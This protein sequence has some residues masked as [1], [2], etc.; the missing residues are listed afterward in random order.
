MIPQRYDKKNSGS[1]GIGQVTTPHRPQ[2][3]ILQGVGDIKHNALCWPQ[4]QRINFLG[5][6]AVL[7][8]LSVTSSSDMTRFKTSDLPEADVEE[9][10]RSSGRGVDFGAVTLN[11]SNQ[12][13]R[14]LQ[15]IKQPVPPHDKYIHAF[16]TETEKRCRKIT[17]G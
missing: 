17:G 12:I 4:F 1:S 11:Y 6:P 16:V 3:V 5:L 13:T 7:E 2:A 15:G 10:V 8:M 9:R 14:G